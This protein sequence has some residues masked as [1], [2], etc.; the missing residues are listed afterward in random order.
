MKMHSL[1]RFNKMVSCN[2]K[3][4]AEEEEKR[5]NYLKKKEKEI[6]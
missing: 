4:I 1:E 3:R 6:L 5:F 2:N